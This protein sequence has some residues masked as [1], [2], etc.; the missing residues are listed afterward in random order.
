M[1]I[2]ELFAITDKKQHYIFQILR[3]W[4]TENASKL[5]FKNP[6]TKLNSILM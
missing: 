3:L 5:D 1:E 6:N 4:G 2:L